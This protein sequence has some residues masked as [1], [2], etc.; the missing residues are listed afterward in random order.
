MGGGHGRTV[1]ADGVVPS[2]RGALGL[3][4]LLL[5]ERGLRDDLGLGKCWG[6]RGRCW[7]CDCDWWLRD[8]LVC[9]WGRRD[10]VLRY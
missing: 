7:G 1:A 4:R 2:E 3:L 5:R 8:S 10:T 9:D 6:G